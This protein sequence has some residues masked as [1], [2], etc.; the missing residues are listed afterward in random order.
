MHADVLP[1]T[2]IARPCSSSAASSCAATSTP[3]KRRANKY[4]SI[5]KIDVELLFE[6]CTKTLRKKAIRK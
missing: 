5:F 6:Y 4:L 2:S 3:T 1:S